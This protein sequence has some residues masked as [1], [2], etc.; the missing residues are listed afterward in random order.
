MVD[1]GSSSGTIPPVLSCEELK[2]LMLEGL[3]NVPGS[4]SPE[5]FHARFDHLERGLQI[6]DVIYGIETEWKAC[7]PLRFN[8]KFWQWNYE[9]FT[10]NADGERL[11][12]IVAVDTANRSFE[13]ITRWTEDTT[14]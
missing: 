4:G 8:R 14:A 12:L 7:R 3:E 5:T 9:I 2:R 13:V 11:T 6:D 10:E 1:T